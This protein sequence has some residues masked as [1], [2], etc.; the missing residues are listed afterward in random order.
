MRTLPFSIAASSAFVA[1]TY[2]LI[3][4]V[5]DSHFGKFLVLVCAAILTISLLDERASIS[6]QIP[7]AVMASALWGCYAAFLT[8]R[9]SSSFWA[10][11]LDVAAVG[12]TVYLLVMRARV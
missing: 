5:N 1:F 8:Q 10:V 3:T 4:G 2:I 6:S 11:V 9:L 12:S 7:A